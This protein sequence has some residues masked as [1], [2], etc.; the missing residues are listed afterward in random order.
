MGQQIIYGRLLVS[1]IG[2][3]PRAKWFFRVVKEVK[4]VSKVIRIS[5]SNYERLKSLS[6]GFE[7]PYQ[8]IDRLLDYYDQHHKD[9]GELKEGRGNCRKVEA[10]KEYLRKKKRGVDKK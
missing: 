8:V 7:H 9:K 1:H 4:K 6:T 10:L 3:F 5:S 2:I